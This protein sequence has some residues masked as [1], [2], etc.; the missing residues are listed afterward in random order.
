FTPNDASKLVDSTFM[1]KQMPVCLETYIKAEY[2]NKK[3]S[4]WNPF[5]KF[6]FIRGCVEQV[7][8]TQKSF[9]HIELSNAPQF[10]RC[11]SEEL[12]TKYEYKN[13]EGQNLNSLIS[14]S[15]SC[16]EQ[17]YPLP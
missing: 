13:L 8:S 7:K 14:I 6:Q 3:E 11:L 12:E 2:P 9:H 1:R 4:K 5:Q 15:K 17:Q 16:F 10:C